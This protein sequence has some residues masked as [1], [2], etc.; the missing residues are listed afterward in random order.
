MTNGGPGMT[1]LD[2]GLLAA[3]IRI[4]A[5]GNRQNAARRLGSGPSLSPHIVYSPLRLPRALEQDHYL[6]ES[7]LLDSGSPLGTAEKIANEHD[8]AAREVRRA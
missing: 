2:S 6:C 7:T 1:H 8:P 5:A 3:G 4:I